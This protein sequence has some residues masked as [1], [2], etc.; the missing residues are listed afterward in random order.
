MIFGATTDTGSLA[1]GTI[2]MTMDGALPVEYLAPG[3]RIVTRNG[4]RVLRDIDTPAPHR[5]ALKFDAPQVIYAD[6]QQLRSDT[7]TPFPA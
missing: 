2:V 6:G 3:D 4:A 7:C 5:F 1:S